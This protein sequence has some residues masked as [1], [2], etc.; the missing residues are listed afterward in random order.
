MH[1]HFKTLADLLTGTRVALA[2]A[3]AW[4][5]LA[6]GAQALPTVVVMVVASWITDL[7]DGPLA[8]RSGVECQTWVGSHDP[9][10]DLS[11]SLGLSTFLAAAGMLR[12]WVAVALALA[13]ILVWVRC[14]YALAWPL[15]ALPYALLIRATLAALPTLGWALI[16]YL[17]G[18]ALARRR[19]VMEE[20]LP[21]FS[22][23]VDHI[24]QRGAHRS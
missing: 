15:Y 22:Q 17:S 23:A 5:G 14:S 18:L 4:Q 19:R 3:I 13:T 10:A 8:R 6:R 2:A 7:L 11:T 21:L 20:Y 16:L 12:P 9:E 1:K 24:L